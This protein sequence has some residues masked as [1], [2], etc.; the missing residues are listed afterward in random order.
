MP[1]WSL[2]N[3]KFW[4]YLEFDVVLF[5]EITKLFCI[6]NDEVLSISIVEDDQHV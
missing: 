2:L 1:S 5:M 6:P 4:Q 3:T